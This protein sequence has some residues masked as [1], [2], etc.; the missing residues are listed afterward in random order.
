MSALTGENTGLS[1]RLQQLENDIQAVSNGLQ[2]VT[3]VDTIL[4]SYRKEMTRQLEELERRRQDSEKEGERLRKIERD[5]VNKSLVELRRGL[6]PS[7]SSSARPAAGKK[8][9]PASPV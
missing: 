8:K 2:R 6:E 7:P 3:K 9:R 5:T 1:R 4:D